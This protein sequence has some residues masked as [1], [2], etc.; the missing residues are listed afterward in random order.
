M[1]RSHTARQAERLMETAL[2][3]GKPHDCMTPCSSICMAGP[4]GS[5]GCPGTCVSNKAHEHRC[6]TPV[7]K[8]TAA[9]VVLAH[10][11]AACRTL[12]HHSRATVPALHQ[13][14][15]PLICPDAC[16]RSW[17]PGLAARW[18]ACS[19]AQLPHRWY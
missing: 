5:M 15:H 10:R 2:C 16:T 6:C 14:R 8:R 13:A 3:G 11:P 7:R 19:R 9:C 12:P 17:R 18:R 4:V 1:L